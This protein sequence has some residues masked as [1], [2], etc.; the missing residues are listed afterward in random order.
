[1]ATQPPTPCRYCDGPAT[2]TL[3]TV[4]V[5]E[6]CAPV[7]KDIRARQLETMLAELRRVAREQEETQE[8]A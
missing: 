8:A 3:G 1:M 2:Q 5:C 7:V 6:T 4:P